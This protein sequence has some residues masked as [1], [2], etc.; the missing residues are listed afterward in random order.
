MELEVLV[1]LGVMRVELVLG[2]RAVDLA[3]DGLRVLRNAVE[4]PWPLRTHGRGFAA[5]ERLAPLF[6]GY[7]ISIDLAPRL[8]FESQIHSATC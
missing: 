1:R 6:V 4:R 5:I 3:V 7:D 2:F 8:S